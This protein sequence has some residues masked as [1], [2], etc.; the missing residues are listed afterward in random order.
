VAA[1][2]LL[3][4]GIGF[5]LSSEEYFLRVDQYAK[6]VYGE[7][8]SGSTPIEAFSGRTAI[9]ERA[10]HTVRDF[11]ITGMGLNTFP[12]AMITFYPP[13]TF[14][15]ATDITHAHNQLLIVGTDL[16]IPGLITYLALLIGMGIMLWQSWQHSQHGPE[17]M[18]AVGFAA[19]LLAFELFGL[20]DGIGL[21]EK[22]SIFFWFLLGLAAGLHRLVHA[23]TLPKLTNLRKLGENTKSE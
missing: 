4:L 21:G 9:W 22:P 15:N 6:A 23:P 17:K 19:S 18:L 8:T 12:Q 7:T 13:L 11:P 10:I 20:F 3:I 14:R 2:L 16:G 5:L 1:V